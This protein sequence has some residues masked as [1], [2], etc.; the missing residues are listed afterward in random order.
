MGQNPV[1]YNRTARPHVLFVDPDT[2][3]PLTPDDEGNVFREFP[4]GARRTYRCHDG[5]FDF[6]G[7]SEEKEYYDS[8]YAGIRL[9]TS[10]VQDL[11]RE[12]RSCPE[13][14]LLLESMGR[15]AGKRILLLGNGTSLKE[16]YLLTLGARLVYTDLS[17]Q[18]VM[19][20]KSA[21]ADSELNAYSSN[22]EFHAVDALRLPFPPASF[23]IAYGCCFAHHLADLHL[24]LSE[25]H[26][27][28]KAD[29]ICRFL[30][31]AYSS[32]WQAA[33]KTV[34]KPVQAYAHARHGLSP[35]DMRATRR[36]GYRREELLALMDQCG[37]RTLYFRRVSF[38]RR[39]CE[40]GA[41]KLV[42]YDGKLYRSCSEGSLAAWTARLDSYLARR[43]A[44]FEGNLI[45]LVWGFDNGGRTRR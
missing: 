9:S 40:R 18:A 22:V 36:G 23:D 12:W 17:L 14:V 24:F 4:R 34:L 11:E 5:V 33:K 29:G 32:I 15:L 2:K 16:L 41:G 21:L 27:C 31:D 43:S 42:G 13:H 30:D 19:A 25:V 39:L 20:V 8:H 38:F 7:A 10:P 26:D 35:E 6:V 28:L 37:F 44:W 1:T 3:E 45:N